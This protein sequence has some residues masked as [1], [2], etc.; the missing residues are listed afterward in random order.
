MAIDLLPHDPINL[1]QPPFFVLFT[2]T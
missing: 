2:L 1:A